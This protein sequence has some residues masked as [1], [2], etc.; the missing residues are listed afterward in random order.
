MDL[1]LRFR[2]LIVL[3]A[4]LI[5]SCNSGS[6][7][8][9]PIN[10]STH[11]FRIFSEEM[12]CDVKDFFRGPWSFDGTVAYG[13]CYAPP[14]VLP[15]IS[16]PS[17]RSNV[18]CDHGA[19][20]V[21]AVCSTVHNYF[22][23]L[24]IT[25]PTS[26]GC[27]DGVEPAC[28]MDEQTCLDEWFEC[29]P[30]DS[31]VRLSWPALG[32]TCED[33]ILTY[34]IVAEVIDDAAAS[35]FCSKRHEEC[36]QATDCTSSQ[37]PSGDHCGTTAPSIDAENQ[38]YD[39]FDGG[40][41]TPGCPASDDPA[42]PVGLGASADI[43]FIEH[44]EKRVGELCAAAGCESSAVCRP[45]DGTMGYSDGGLGIQG[46]SGIKDDSFI[47]HA[48]VCVG[49]GPEVCSDTE[50]AEALTGSEPCAEGAEVDDTRDALVPGSVSHREVDIRCQCSS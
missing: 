12:D 15:V 3:A 20:C 48:R 22:C 32:D 41:P 17:C 26:F 37:R 19:H 47:G 23:A 45:A 21:D 35:A 25:E 43:A 44:A 6:P 16:G 7:Y 10:D 31:G 39:C 14:E 38:N 40:A 13:E 27:N 36:A 9:D 28:N 5:A 46:S 42:W 50:R 29:L 49:D 4:I 1:T 33:I 11:G 2:F 18:D 30:G 8:T 34:E 24:P